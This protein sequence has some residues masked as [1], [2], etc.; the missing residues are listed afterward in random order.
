M[1]P[2]LGEREGGLMTITE[3]LRDLEFTYR[4][5][6]EKYD[7]SY[8]EVDRCLERLDKFRKGELNE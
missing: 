8:A 7:V 2:P 3:L 1:L 4:M 5:C 6:R